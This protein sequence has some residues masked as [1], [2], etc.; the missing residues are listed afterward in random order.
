MMKKI[1]KSLVGKSIALGL[2]VTMVFST[3]IL[4]YSG[5]SGEF[6][7]SERLQQ[8]SVTATFEKDE[9]GVV[10]FET[11]WGDKEANIASMD[12]YIEE[13][14]AQCLYIQQQQQVMHGIVQRELAR[15]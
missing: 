1:M 8:P 4:G 10:N 7:R 11:T 5:F 3:S 12:K 15:M 2:S 6:T 9:L 13:V 14:D